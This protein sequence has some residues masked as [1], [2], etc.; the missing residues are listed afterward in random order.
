MHGRHL[1]LSLTLALG[2]ALAA[3][4]GEDAALAAWLESAHRQQAAHVAALEAAGDVE[5]L[6][7]AAF[8]VAP[9][10]PE[11]WDEAAQEALEARRGALFEAARAAGP[12]HPLVAWVAASCVHRAP[13]GECGTA[14]DW[15][16]VEAVA[17]GGMHARLAL[18]TAATQR[19]DGEAAERHWPQAAAESRFRGAPEA[20]AELIWAAFD[21]L[22]VDE[23]EGSA[24]VA[25]AAASDGPVHAPM[26]HW[27]DVAAIAYLA[28]VPMPAYGLL[29]ERCG[30]RAGNPAVD[31]D[32]SLR[33][34]CEHVFTTMHTQGTNLLEQMIAVRALHR[35][36]VSDEERARWDAAWVEVRWLAEQWARSADRF[37][38]EYTPDY[39]Q[40]WREHG[41]AA[42]VRM[43][44]ERL[45]EPTQPPP[46]WRPAGER[47]AA[48][49]D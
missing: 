2:P 32:A 15:A 35:L 40:T 36:A 31:I 22:P 9:I 8:L 45:G 44:L 10:T 23:P 39:T 20:M 25:F 16:R 46:G 24:A 4:A 7:K 3:G 14:E 6:L 5:S 42:A 33:A 30:V 17:A 12:D 19:G 49:P 28:A 43:I 21:G 38:D 29:Y 1:L 27:K 34:Q 47:A 11:S 48:T 37:R 26:A 41:E 13:G 18:Y